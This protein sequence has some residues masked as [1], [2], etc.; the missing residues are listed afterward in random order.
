MSFRDSDF[1]HNHYNAF[2]FKDC[3]KLNIQ[4][5]QNSNFETFLFLYH[6]HLLFSHHFS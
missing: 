6:L 1:M 2:F 4:K 5:Y 3:V